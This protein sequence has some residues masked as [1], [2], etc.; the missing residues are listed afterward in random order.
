MFKSPVL[1]IQ[2]NNMWFYLNDEQVIRT[3]EFKV[4]YQPILMSL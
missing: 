2:V 4:F 1:I 3:T